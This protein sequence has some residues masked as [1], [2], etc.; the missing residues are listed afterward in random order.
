MKI[1]D[2]NNNKYFSGVMMIILNLGSRFLI[3]ELTETQ[4]ELLDKKIIR[5]IV[6]FTIVFTATKDV[7]V[8]FIITILFLLVLNS[9]FNENS[10]YSII[11]VNKKNKKITKEAYINAK[12]II[13]MYK[14]QKN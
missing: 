12:N 4:I 9:L 10:K 13:K 14:N 7:Y 3:K 11:K 8:S 5:K 1:S 2:L 6:I